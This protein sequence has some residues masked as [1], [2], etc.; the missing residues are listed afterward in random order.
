MAVRFSNNGILKIIKVSSKAR[1]NS[2]YYQQNILESIFV[3]EI[4]ALYGKNF[5][6][7]ELQMDRASS[8]TFKSTVTYLINRESETGIKYSSFEEIALKS[9]KAA[10]MEF[11]ASGFS[12]LA[13]GKWQEEWSKFDLTVLRKSIISCKI[14]ARD[15]FKNHGYQTEAN[16]HKKIRNLWIKIN[17]QNCFRKV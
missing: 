5:E 2:L 4:P 9:P 13:L 10:P 8:H 7:V 3:E 17:Y 1:I 12:K 11:C 16:R 15:I 6:K 14:R